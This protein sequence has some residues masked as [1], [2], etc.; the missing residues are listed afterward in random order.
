[1]MLGLALSIFI[2]QTAAPDVEVITLANGMRWVLLARPEEGRV[3]GIVTVRAGGVNESEGLTGAAHLLEHLAFAGTPIVGS[4]RGWRLE[5]PLQERVFDLLDAKAKLMR[6]G[7]GGSVDAALIETSL[8]SAERDWRE[9]GDESAFSNLMRVNEVTINAWT[10]KDTTKYWGDFP[11]EQLHLWLAAEAQR[12]AAPIFRNFQT[13]RDVVLQERVNGQSLLNNAYETLWESAFYGSG[14]AWDTAGLEGDL[15][16]MSPRSIERFYERLYAPNNSVGCL[17]GDFDRAQARV[18]LAETF[19]QIPARPV[20]PPPRV[21]LAAPRRLSEKASEHWVILGFEVPAALDPSS[22]PFVTLEY[23][24]DGSE[25]PFKRL[26]EQLGVCTQIVIRSGPGVQQR[27]LMTIALRL[28]AGIS[29]EEAR[30]SLFRSLR[31][32]TPSDGELERARASL[33]R[34]RLQ[35]L[36]SRQRLAVALAERVLLSDEWRAA[37]AP[38]LSTRAGVLSALESFTPERAWVVEV[39]P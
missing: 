30:E 20:E 16:A 39:S 5:A 35:G 14:Y 34:G 31:E 1:M 32:W 19:G 11:S 12:F 29:A 18:W 9:K 21:R 3:S 33:E 17:V 26:T 28:R 6:V 37:F 22:P 2:T 8:V 25:G 10:T 36:R 23:L 7:R 15:R 13:E 4:R 38:P 27:H 24:L